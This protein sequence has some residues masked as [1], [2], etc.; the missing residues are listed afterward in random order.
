MNL[1]HCTEDCV[2]QEDGY[3]ALE[4]PTVICSLERDCCFFEKQKPIAKK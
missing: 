3:C 2:H 4:N 1:I